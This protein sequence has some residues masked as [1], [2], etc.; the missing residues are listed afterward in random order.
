MNMTLQDQEPP[1]A[2]DAAHDDAGWVEVARLA[3]LPPLG[4]RVVEGAARGPI[5][6]FRAQDDH[7]FALLDRCPH[8]GGPLSQGV[9]HGHTVTCP[10]HAWKIGLDSGEAVAPDR[11]CV[12]RFAVRVQD[13]RILLK[14]AELA[15]KG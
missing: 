11:G 10:L 6:V 4:A 13:G 8:R 15:D 7:V 1:V 2:Q 5:A 3:D 14:A 12:H 9:V